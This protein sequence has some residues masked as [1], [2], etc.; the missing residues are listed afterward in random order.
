M[1]ILIAGGGS[2]GHILPALAVVR[3]LRERRADVEPT[4]VGGRRGLEASLVPPSGIPLERLWLRSLRSVDRS[5]NTILDPVRLALSVPQAIWLLARLRPRAIFTTG[6]YVAIPVLLAARLLRIPSLLWEGN[7]VPGRS[8]RAVA[9][10]ASAIAV[11]YAPTA[12][13][14]PGRAYLTGT[15]VRSFDGL[16]RDTSRLRLGL[17]ATGHVLLAFGGS[18]AVR[19]IDDAIAAALL[20]LVGRTVVLHVT[21]DEGYAT[22]LQHREA[23]PERLRERYRPVPFLREEMADALVAADLI[24][25]RAGSSTLAEATTLGRP[26]IVVPYPHAGGHQRANA[27]ALAAA[28]AAI[29]IDDAHFDGPAL[30]EAVAVLDRPDR[31]AAMAAA[32]REAGHPG[33][34]EANAALLLALAEREPPPTHD[35]IRAIVAARP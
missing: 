13:E 15:P 35:A 20:E 6:G 27:A 12:D 21:G 24:L 1:R 7:L 23:L 22:A 10:L 4:W 33:A 19:R 3:S 5:V 31:L 17:S 8:V 18:Q 26:L 32:S 29:V 2:G 34:A 11:S 25:G 16:T 9:R 14:L 30:L 28:G